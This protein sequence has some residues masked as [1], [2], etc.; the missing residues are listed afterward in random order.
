MCLY[1]LSSMMWGPLR[2]P[3]KNGVRFVG[4]VAYPMLP[5]FLYCSFFI[6]PSLLSNVYFMSK[7]LLLL[8]WNPR[9]NQHGGCKIKFTFISINYILCQNK[10]VLFFY[11]KY[12]YNNHRKLYVKII[13][14]YFSTECIFQNRTVLSRFS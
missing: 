13:L 14:I 1:V 6:A 3:H 4:C 12:L 2:F 5:V 11:N 9:G 7:K 10:S 8:W